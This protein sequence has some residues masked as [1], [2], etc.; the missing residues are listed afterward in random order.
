MLLL[1]CGDVESNPGPLTNL[2]KK[3]AAS[4]EDID[5]E[6]YVYVSVL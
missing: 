4:A 5:K 2:E 3:Q 1:L 6:A